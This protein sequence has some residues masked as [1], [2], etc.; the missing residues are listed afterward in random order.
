MRA[1]GCFVL[2]LRNL[3]RRPALALSLALLYFLTCF[4]VSVCFLFSAAGTAGAESLLNEDPRTNYAG[5]AFVGSAE[6]WGADYPELPGAAALGALLTAVSET[7]GV[8]E[9]ALTG[10]CSF[11]GAYT[12]TGNDVSYT[13]EWGT[14]TVLASPGGALPQTHTGYLARG[15][16]A[17]LYGRA[18]EGGAS[19]PEVLVSQTFA[20]ENG[21]DNAAD[22]VG[23]TLSAPTLL[24]TIFS[25]SADDA[26]E[27]EEGSG[28]LQIGGEEGSGGVQI[29][30]VEHDFLPQA[31]IV[32]VAADELGTAAG[33]P[34]SFV[35]ADLD[36]IR[37]KDF[38]LYELR[39]YCAYAEK[40]AVAAR[41]NASV[42]ESA[43]FAACEA[44]YAVERFGDI[45][46]FITAVLAVVFVLFLAAAVLADVSASAFLYGKKRA[47]CRAAFAC[48]Y[49][50]GALARTEFVQSAVL[51]LAGGVLALPLAYLAA[52][53][54]FSLLAALGYGAAAFSF[55]AAVLPVALGVQLLAAGAAALAVRAGTRRLF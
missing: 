30:Y 16:G 20:R 40:E 28:G 18:P 38:F 45:V 41:L 49:S 55:H 19:L 29:G 35:W 54:G 31:Q 1:R 25:V 46:E 26:P 3:R 27:G 34:D 39:A 2:A 53:G 4:F 13:R 8:D 7:E 12:L 51:S 44:P 23:Y 32:G 42:E 47:F 11:L 22:I 37:T 15:G 48:G 33:G 5:T 52:R 9:A 24:E 6:K 14:M 17:V 36:A 50:R 10:S 21:F 43:A